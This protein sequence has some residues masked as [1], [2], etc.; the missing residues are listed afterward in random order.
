[1]TCGCSTD[2]MPSLSGP[3]GLARSGSRVSGTSAASSRIGWCRSSSNRWFGVTLGW[4]GWCEVRPNLSP[5][6]L[7]L[8][9]EDHRFVVV[10]GRLQALSW[11]YTRREV[12]L[13]CIA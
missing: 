1:M 5:D 12:V 11:S 3:V 7:S 4:F 10:L 6:A 8:L 13:F 9:H 2:A